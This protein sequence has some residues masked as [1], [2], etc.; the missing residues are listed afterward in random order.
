MLNRRIPEINS[1]IYLNLH[2]AND[3]RREERPINAFHLENL[4]AVEKDGWIQRPQTINITQHPKHME[5]YK[6][7]KSRMEKI[8][9]NFKFKFEAVYEPIV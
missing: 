6:A 1:Y 9:V 2:V 4:L 7:P 8:Q 3:T 5:E